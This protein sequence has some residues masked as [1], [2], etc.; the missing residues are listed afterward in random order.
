[1]TKYSGGYFLQ[2]R[3]RSAGKSAGQVTSGHPRPALQPRLSLYFVNLSRSACCGTGKSRA[4]PRCRI[5]GGL[6]IA[7]RARYTLPGA[8]LICLFYP[9]GSREVQALIQVTAPSDADETS[10][11]YLAKTPV[12]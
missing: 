7:K 1:M 8:P 12:L 5:A 9:S 4:L 6:H 2:R 11:A 10:V 3:S